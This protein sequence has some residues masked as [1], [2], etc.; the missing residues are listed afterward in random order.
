MLQQDQINSPSSLHELFRTHY[1]EVGHTLREL[2]LARRA[3]VQAEAQV[4]VEAGRA[5][6]LATQNTLLQERL[7]AMA[8]EML[9]LTDERAKARTKAAKSDI[10]VE[11]MRG[12]TTIACSGAAVM[13]A[14]YE[15][16]V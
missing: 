5:T 14:H 13:A 11:A 4:A 10:A 9:A 2:R 7:D 15:Y 12:A 1:D 8:A 6:A 3:L 16:S